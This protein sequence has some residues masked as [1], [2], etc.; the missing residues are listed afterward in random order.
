MA[1]RAEA[2][3]RGFSV[4]TVNVVDLERTDVC[5]AA[6]F[7]AETRR[8]RCDDA[9]GAVDPAAVPVRSRPHPPDGAQLD[10]L[11]ER[12]GFSEARELQVHGPIVDVEIPESVAEATALVRWGFGQPP[13][14]LRIVVE[15]REGK[16]PRGRVSA[17]KRCWWSRSHQ[18][19]SE[20]PQPCAVPIRRVH[21]RF[22]LSR[23]VPNRPRP[24]CPSCGRA[25]EPLYRASS[26]KGFPRVPNVFW[27]E[28]DSVLARGR[29]SPKFLFGPGRR[30]VPR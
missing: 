9:G 29:S 27:C 28:A 24:R 21:A 6:V 8:A 22:D 26:R 2:A 20:W 10:G 4:S 23:V 12:L 11:E 16:D 17:H 15:S 1:V 25:M 30:A 5:V 3:K 19:Y 18:C 7:A 13:L 14:D